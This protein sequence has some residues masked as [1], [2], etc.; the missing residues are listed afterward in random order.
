MTLY[1]SELGGSQ[2][3]W[4]GVTFLVLL[5]L[6]LLSGSAVPM[7]YSPHDDSLYLLRAFHLLTVLLRLPRS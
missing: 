1:K 7:T 3:L 5:K 6:F 4:L 2:L